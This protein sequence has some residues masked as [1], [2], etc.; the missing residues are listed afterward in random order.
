MEGINQT[1]V[2]IVKSRKSKLLEYFDIDELESSK[3]RCQLGLHDIWKKF[4][5]FTDCSMEI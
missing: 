3:N 5:A 1:I 2:K 4:V